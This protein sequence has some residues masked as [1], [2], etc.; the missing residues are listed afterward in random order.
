MVRS[1]Y[2]QAPLNV[3]NSSLREWGYEVTAVGDGNAALEVLRRE[4]A[5]KMAILD[6]MMPGLDGLE[7]CRRVRAVDRPEPTYIIVLTVKGGKHNIITALE[8][9]A[10][11]Y[12]TKPFDRE[13]L[14]ARLKVGRRIVGLQTSQTVVFTFARAVE[15]KSP[16]TRSSSF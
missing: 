5:P 7:V 2:L 9:G 14:Q 1:F 13:E 10:D 12:L 3:Q 16:F 6:W 11:D 4:D 8:S 15:A